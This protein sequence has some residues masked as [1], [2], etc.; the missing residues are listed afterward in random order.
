MV[1]PGD[2]HREQAALAV[3]AAHLGV[4]VFL[5]DDQTE[6][7]MYDLRAELGG[8]RF[9]AI[10]VTAAE[11]ERRAADFGALA[12]GRGTVRVPQLQSGWLVY[13]REGAKIR[14][15]KRR[16]PTLLVEMERAGL[17]ELVTSSGWFGED[18]EDL[19]ER[20]WASGV[21]AVY[22]H[23]N[24]GPGVISM[25]GAAYA[26]WLSTDPDDVVSFVES[27]VESRPSDVAKLGRSSGDE[28]HMFIWSG[29]FSTAEGE[30]RALALDINQM[31]AR[32][33]RL[34]PE[35]THVWVA[36]ETARPSRIVHWSPTHGWIQAGRVS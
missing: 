20:L 19:R 34:P 25:T 12:R 9:A 26:T 4:Q 30:L 8:R 35:V 1:R 5:H 18:L 29:M 23:P 13:L 24:P 15:V 11:D 17:T 31:P 3:V 27:F 21:A 32:A 33:P 16:L 6:P 22:E 10:E 7:G 36:S 14:E 28:R 2:D